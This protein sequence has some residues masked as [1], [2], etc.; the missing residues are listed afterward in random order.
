M[1]LHRAAIACILAFVPGCVVTTEPLGIQLATTPMLHL[2]IGAQPVVV[3][4]LGTPTIDGTFSPG[5]WANATALNFAANVPAAD[6]GGT[7]PVTLYVM[8]DAASLYLALKIARGSI[9]SG[10]GT[11]VVFEFD[12]DHSGGP[13]PAEGDDAVVFNIG[14][15]GPLFIDL[16]RT[17]QPPL[18]RTDNVF[19]GTAD[20]SGAG[21]NDGA[22]T[23]FEL[24]HPLDGADDTHD[25]SLHP[26]DVVGFNMILTLWGVPPACAG[27]S[28]DCTADTGLPTLDFFNR[29]LFADL[30]L[31]T[32]ALPV[33]I[34]V[35]PGS[36]AITINL[37]SNGT[38][39]VAILSTATFDATTVD[40]ATVDF[41]GAPVARRPNG[42]WMAAPVDV[43]GDGLG[44]LVVHVVT[45]ALQ[46]DAGFVEAVLTGA[47]LGGQQIMGS[48]WVRI[49]H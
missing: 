43:N 23:Y 37:K 44:D 15:F 39:P 28:A 26:G 13:A 8:N 31:A 41:A 5:E 29:S 11:N 6:G 47:T 27:G 45:S 30:Q 33:N 17:L 24:S 22:F 14:F 21:S 4:G 7:T 34:D 20:G 9:G 16:Y 42:S 3:S 25:F 10:G 1:S 18:L 36:D 49:V 46:L 35:K 19:G 38:T 40:P 48:D 2:P 12:N 32:L